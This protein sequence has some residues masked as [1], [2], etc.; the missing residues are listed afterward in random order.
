M[1]DMIGP[2]EHSGPRAGLS[3]D[4]IVVAECPLA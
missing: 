3:L 4:E 2:F 1:S